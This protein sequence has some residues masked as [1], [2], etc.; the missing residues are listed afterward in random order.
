MCEKEIIIKRFSFCDR[1]RNFRE[2]EKN[3]AHSGMEQWQVMYYNSSENLFVSTSENYYGN[4]YSKKK[5]SFK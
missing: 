2:Q 1:R 3:L 5:K 4:T